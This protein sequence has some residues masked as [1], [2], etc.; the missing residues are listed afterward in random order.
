MMTAYIEY[1]NEKMEGSLWI[2]P[3]KF[4]PCSEADLNS[5]KKMID[6]CHVREQKRDFVRELKAGLDRLLTEA[7][8]RRVELCAMYQC[9]EIS[10]KRAVREL[11]ELES[12]INRLERNEEVIQ[13]WQEE[14]QTSSN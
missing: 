4:F 12:R 6:S 11:K 5:I 3:E 13:K 7:H 1:W 2:C 14:L 9:R 10:Q 8:Q